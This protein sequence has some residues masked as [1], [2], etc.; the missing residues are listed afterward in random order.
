MMK[1]TP[2]EEMMMQ[3]TDATSLTEQERQEIYGVF[4]T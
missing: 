1:V 2:T 3:G 4:R